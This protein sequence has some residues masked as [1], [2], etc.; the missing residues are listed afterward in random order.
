MRG[1]TLAPTKNMAVISNNQSR[2]QFLLDMAKTA[3]GVGMFGLGLGLYARQAR[4]LPP[5]AI[6]EYKGFNFVIVQDG[7]RR[8]R[9]EINE[10]GLKGED[11][12]EIKADLQEGDQVLGILHPA[13]ITVHPV[14]HHL[15]AAHGIGGDQWPGHRRGFQQGARRALAIGRQHHAIR[16]RD[17]LAHVV[18]HAEVVHHALGHPFLHLLA[19][20]RRRVLHVQKAQQPELAGLLGTKPEK[21]VQT[22]LGVHFAIVLKLGGPQAEGLDQLKNPEQAYYIKP[23]GS[24]QIALIA[25]KP[26]GLY[27]AKV[28]V[29]GKT[30]EAKTIDLYSPTTLWKQKVYDTG[31]LTPGSHTIEIECLGTKNSKAWYHTIDVDRF[32]VMLT[33]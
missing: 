29:D 5:S 15:A 31:I 16:L 32:D 28:T 6:R 9:V 24:D 20:D 1:K 25:L 4:A 30:A 19:R 7:D 21:A 13:Q 2:R 8:R 22:V 33:P 17:L 27:A 18:A 14:L 3:F 11:L 26:A 12:W 23:Y 10:I